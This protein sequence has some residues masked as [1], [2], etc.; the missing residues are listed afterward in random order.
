MELSTFDAYE[1][2]ASRTA[3]GLSTETY[4]YP[5]LGLVGEAGEVSEKIKKRY[6]DCAGNV[7]E[8]LRDLDWRIELCKELGDV[9]W[10][11]TRIAANAGFSLQNVAEA[12]IAKLR[13]R[14]ER[15]VIHGSGDN[16]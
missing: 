12:N 10:Y 1:E 14:Q 11:L 2:E 8:S 3:K 13:S 4:W 5:A 6:R 16:R 9:L 15:G 7:E